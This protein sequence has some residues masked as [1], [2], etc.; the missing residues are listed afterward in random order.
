M[1]LF[2]VAVAIWGAWWLLPPISLN[3]IPIDSRILNSPRGQHLGQTALFTVRSGSGMSQESGWQLI[4]LSDGKI[5][6]GEVCGMQWGVSP[7]GALLICKSDDQFVVLETATGNQLRRSGSYPL[8]SATV[9]QHGLPIRF[10]ADG[11]RFAALINDGVV[12]FETATMRPIAQFENEGNAFDLSAN[13]KLLLAQDRSSA[14]LVLWDVESQQIVSTLM[15]DQPAVLEKARISPRGDFVAT[16]INRILTTDADQNDAGQISVWGC[17]NTA[18]VLTLNTSGDEMRFCQEG[19]F[20]VAGYPGRN[21]FVDLGSEPPIEIGRKLADGYTDRCVSEDGSALLSHDRQNSWR[22]NS[23]ISHSAVAQGA[24]NSSDFSGFQVGFSPKGKWLW[25]NGKVSSPASAPWKSWLE[26]VTGWH[27]TYTYRSD[28][29]NVNTGLVDLKLND[30]QPAL[31]D[32]LQFAVWTT[33]IG[34]FKPG[35]QFFLEQWHLGRQYPPWWLWLVTVIGIGF[36]V[37]DLKRQRRAGEA[38]P[39]LQAKPL[40]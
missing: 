23:T 16:F 28:I 24:F 19:R 18:E 15:N 13:G 1:V 12:V 32:D 34:A 39:R 33:P 38:R 31:F 11:G 22:V 9:R 25:I 27:L 17:K 14:R 36:I 7:N 40:V 21:L 35:D 6:G 10:S 2:F 37:F 30:R 8:D 20:L 5:L 29:V 3:K 4:R 26:E